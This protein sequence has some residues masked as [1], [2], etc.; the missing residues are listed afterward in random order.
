MFEILRALITLQEACQK[1]G[2]SLRWD[3]YDNPGFGLAV[4]AEIPITEEDQKF[5]EDMRQL[6]GP[7]EA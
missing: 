4:K 6:V 1:H 5:I 3:V 7:V 2:T